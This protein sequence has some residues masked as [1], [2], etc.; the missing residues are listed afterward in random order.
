MSLRIPPNL[1]LRSLQISTLPEYGAFD[2]FAAM[3][4]LATLTMLYLFH[5]TLWNKSD[6]Y[7]YEMYEKP[8]MNENSSNLSK[9]TR[10]I[11]HK[12]EQTVRNAENLVLGLEA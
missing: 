9:S 8:Q 3:A 7:L 6:P 5:G 10:D 1:D 2:D 11:G 4:V 12:L